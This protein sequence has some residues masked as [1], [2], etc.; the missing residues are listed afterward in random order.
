MVDHASNFI[1]LLTNTSSNKLNL[2]SN[3]SQIQL[4]NFHIPRTMIYA[5]GKQILA[6]NCM[7]KFHVNLITISPKIMQEPQVNLS[8]RF[9]GESSRQSS[10][11]TLCNS[12]VRWNKVRHI[13]FIKMLMLHECLLCSYFS[14]SWKMHMRLFIVSTSNR[15][16]MGLFTFVHMFCLN[17][18]ANLRMA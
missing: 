16:V 3:P 18:N 1:N 6:T 8:R 5:W 13:H 4:L 12:W 14:L 2:S 7:W 10:P 11:R 17:S 9:N 15:E